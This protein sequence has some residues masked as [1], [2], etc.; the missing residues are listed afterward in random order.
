MQTPTTPTTTRREW[1]ASSLSLPALASLPRHAQAAILRL[2][3]GKPGPADR[4]WSD[5]GAIMREA[6]LAPDPWQEEVLRAADARLMLCCSR[7]VGKSATAAAVA[8]FE[9][10]T[11][12]GS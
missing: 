1:L 2:G 5:P 7:Q 4:Y 9:A 3:K 8:L 10:L 11:H 12:P 6:G